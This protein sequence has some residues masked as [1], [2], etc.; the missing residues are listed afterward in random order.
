MLGQRKLVDL[1]ENVDGYDSDDSDLIPFA[2]A[3]ETEEELRDVPKPRFLRICLDS[4]CFTSCVWV[5]CSPDQHH[6][7]FFV[8]VVVVNLAF[9]SQ[10]ALVARG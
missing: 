2:D 6:H 3:E 10:C 9:L 5:A 8:V 4:K 1:T 7:S